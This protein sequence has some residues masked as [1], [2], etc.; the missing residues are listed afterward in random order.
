MAP[1]TKIEEINNKK[2]ATNFCHL[3]LNGLK[4]IMILYDKLLK[5]FH[6]WH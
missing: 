5:E 6:P 4:R 2:A 1:I 3:R